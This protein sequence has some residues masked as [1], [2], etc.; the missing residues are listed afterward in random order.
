[1]LQGT[2]TAGKDGVIRKVL[3]GVD[4]VNFRMTAF[5]QPTA[6]EL[7]HDFLWRIHKAVPARGQVGIFNRSHYEDVL[8]PRVH[9]LVP[10]AEWKQRYEQINDFERLLTANGTTIVKFFLHISKGEQ[11]D[12]LESRLK[13]AK[14]R[15]KFKKHD[16]D[17]RKLW[18][19]YQK[20]YA[21]MLTECNTDESPVVHRAV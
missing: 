10:E 20:A 18:D 4:P 7:S 13:N 12:R 17:E 9:Q 21:A 16:L 8:V 19:K 11:R 2:D 14:K 6:E 1:M 5:R 15:W 3:S